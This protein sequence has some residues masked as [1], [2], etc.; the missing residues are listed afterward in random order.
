MIPPGRYIK[1]AW[2]LD[3]WTL[4]T[5]YQTIELYFRLFQYTKSIL[6]ARKT[7]YIYSKN[8]ISSTFSLHFRGPQNA[9]W[10]KARFAWFFARFARFTPIFLVCTRVYYG[11]GKGIYPGYIMTPRKVYSADA[12]IEPF[13]KYYPARGLGFGWRWI[14]WLEFDLPVDCLLCLP[15]APK[16]IKPVEM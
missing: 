11:G 3:T 14:I 13:G 8:G 4:V 15:N 12:K 1:L 5:I 9:F 16:N 10:R 7:G 6:W 2:S